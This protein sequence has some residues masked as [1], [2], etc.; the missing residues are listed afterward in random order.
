MLNYSSIPVH[1]MADAVKDYIEKGWQPGHFLSA[2]IK[3]DLREA[4]GRADNTNIQHL[5]DWVI[6]FY[7][8]APG[9]CWGSPEK[10]QSWIAQFKEGAA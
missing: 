3:N 10:F 4:V 9:S 2:V 1:Y 7:N 6:W 8:E 5:A